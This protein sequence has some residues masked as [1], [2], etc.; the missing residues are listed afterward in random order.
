MLSFAGWGYVLFLVV[1]SL[2]DTN[3][4]YTKVYDNIRNE[5]TIVQACATLEV[6]K[7]KKKRINSIK[8]MYI[9]I[10]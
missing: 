2:I 1:K 6:N 4:D 8:K 3:G 7:K 5:L 10:K 9:R